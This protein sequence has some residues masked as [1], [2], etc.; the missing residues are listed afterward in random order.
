VT[1][2]DASGIDNQDVPAH[3]ALCIRTGSS[4]VQKSEVLDCADDGSLVLDY[5]ASGRIVSIE[6]A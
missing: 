6:F 3:T 2:L 1:L 5:D 4:A